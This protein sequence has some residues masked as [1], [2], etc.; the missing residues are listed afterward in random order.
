MDEWTMEKF[1]RLEIAIAMAKAEIEKQS[2]D[3]K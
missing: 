3:R 1:Q 2:Q